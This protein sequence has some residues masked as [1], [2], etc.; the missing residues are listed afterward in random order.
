[1]F[2][3][4][5]DEYSAWWKEYDARPFVK[6][7]KSSLNGHIEKSQ[8]RSPVQSNLEDRGADVLVKYA[9]KLNLVLLRNICNICNIHFDAFHQIFVN[10]QMQIGENWVTSSRLPVITST[11]LVEQGRW[12]ASSVGSMGQIES[13]NLTSSLNLQ[14]REIAA[15]F[16]N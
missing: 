5:Q 10:C 11:P 12:A 9:F 2:F 6:F 7:R 15:S 3:F 13:V 16:I 4:P 14:T 8:P 1:V